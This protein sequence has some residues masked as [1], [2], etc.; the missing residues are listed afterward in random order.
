MAEQEEMVYLA[1]GKD[2]PKKAVDAMDELE[3]IWP[4]ASFVNARPALAWVVLNSVGY[5]DKKEK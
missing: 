2:V 5:F 4:G 3:L 1:N